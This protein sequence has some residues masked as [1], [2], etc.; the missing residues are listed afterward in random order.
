MARERRRGYERER[1]RSYRVVPVERETWP[2]WC[3]EAGAMGLTGN[4][5]AGLILR[6]WWRSRWPLALIPEKRREAKQDPAKK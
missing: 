6:N 4:K 3:A 1:H 5:L 2:A